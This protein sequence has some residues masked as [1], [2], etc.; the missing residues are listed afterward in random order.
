MG[1][2]G[3]VLVERGLDFVEGDFCVGKVER[4]E[5]GGCSEIG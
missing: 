5:F 1:W 2:G 3:K 4:M